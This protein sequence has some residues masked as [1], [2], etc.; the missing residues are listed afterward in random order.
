MLELFGEVGAVK[1]YHENLVP[2][3]YSWSPVDR[4]LTLICMDINLT[5]LLCLTSVLSGDTSVSRNSSADFV[6]I[7]RKTALKVWI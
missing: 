4:R 2:K 7:H 5:N 3:H 6:H 1:S